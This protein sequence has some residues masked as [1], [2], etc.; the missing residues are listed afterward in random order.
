MVTQN[1]LLAQVSSEKARTA[2]THDFIL[3][4]H[5]QRSHFQ[6]PSTEK[7][8]SYF[9]C[10]NSGANQAIASMHGGNS[11][12]TKESSLSPE[13]C[14]LSIALLFP[15][16]IPASSCIL[17]PAL[18][19]WGTQQCWRAECCT[20]REGFSAWNFTCT[21]VE[22]KRTK[23]KST[24]GSTPQATRM[25]FSP[26]REKYKVQY[27]PSPSLDAGETSSITVA[28]CGRAGG[29]NTGFK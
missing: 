11:A 23:W 19:M 14:C 22:V 9:P 3:F 29:E 24:P 25:G 7:F 1:I 8:E 12:N 4:C 6:M 27:P 20:P 26:C 28:T 17:T 18:Q 21:T 5:L 2:H 13:L 16:Q 15:Q 10:M